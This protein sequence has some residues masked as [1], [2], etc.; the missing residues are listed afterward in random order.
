MCVLEPVYAGGMKLLAVVCAA[1]LSLL[2]ADFPGVKT[3]YLLPMSGGLDQYLAIRLTNGGGLQVVTDP[4][5]ADAIFTD[6]I[7]ANFEQTLAD[8]YTPKKA[9][10]GKLADDEVARTVS[11]P[12]SRGKGSFF[13][14][15][16]QSH[17]V[18]WSTYAVSKGTSSQ[19]MNQLAGKIVSELDKS[20][21]AK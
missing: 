18:L 1:G 16:R 12:F 5:K 20:R 6:R 9:Q 13:L 4:Q 8:L 19:E 2:A 3:V 17:V 11:Q 10:D 21:K 14:V 15:D 7:G